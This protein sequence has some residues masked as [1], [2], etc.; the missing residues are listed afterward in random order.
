[1]SANDL[2]YK[3]ITMHVKITPDNFLLAVLLRGMPKTSHYRYVKVTQEDLD[4]D[5]Y[6]DDVPLEGDMTKNRFII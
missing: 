2:P 6:I 3:D 4:N 5:F 1:M